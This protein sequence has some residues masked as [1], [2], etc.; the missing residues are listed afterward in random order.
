MTA[1]SGSTASDS[2]RNVT[3]Y[4]GQDYR[5]T[6]SYLR[7]R[8]PTI[9]DIRPK[10]QQGKYPIGSL[11]TNTSNGHLWCLSQYNGNNTATWTR[12]AATGSAVS[13]VTGNI[14]TAVP[15]PSGNL[16]ITGAANLGVVTV[17]SGNTL[18]LQL[19]GFFLGGFSFSD[20]TE[21][22]AQITAKGAFRTF[23]LP[24]FVSHAGLL[25]NVT[26]LIAESQWMFMLSTNNST[27][28]NNFHAVAM[29]LGNG[30][31]G[32]NVVTL[33]SNP[34]T[35]AFAGSGNLVQI[36]NGSIATRNLN[37]TGI[38]FA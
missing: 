8:D 20:T 29:Y 24:N 22:V 32:F 14:G 34:G 12:I 27:P 19:S 3:R 2:Y 13:E 33:D 21:N 31:G 37:V 5:F 7:S 26:A 16:N 25:E 15:E 1:G 35:V 30:V 36:D 9:N 10:E 38:R 28:D 6:P 17:A 23:N 11:W 4:L 18:S